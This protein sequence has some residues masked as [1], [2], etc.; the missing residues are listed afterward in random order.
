MHHKMEKP[1][2][3]GFIG[4]FIC[5]L[6]IKLRRPWSTYSTNAILVWIHG[7]RNLKWCAQWTIIETIFPTQS[8][9]G[10]SRPTKVSSSIESD[11]YFQA[12]FYGIS[13]RS[14]IE[15]FFIHFKLLG[16]LFGPKFITTLWKLWEKRNGGLEKWSVDSNSLLSSPNVALCSMFSLSRVWERGPSCRT[17]GSHRKIPMHYPY[18]SD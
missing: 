11:I 16:L 9:V 10:I 2:K 7:I 3:I 15:W 5:P 13:R 8:P 14:T 18:V 1:Q 6:C 12:S 17:Y 4:N